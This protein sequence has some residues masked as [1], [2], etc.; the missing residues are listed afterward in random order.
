ML[1]YLHKYLRKPSRARKQEESRPPEMLSPSRNHAGEFAAAATVCC[2]SPCLRDATEQLNSENRLAVKGATSARAAG[3]SNFVK[4]STFS[5]LPNPHFTNHESIPPIL[6][7]FSNFAAV[8]PQY[9]ETQR[10]DVIRDGEYSHLADHVCL[11]YSGVNLFS[12]AQM[13]APAATST[14]FSSTWRPP[15]F[16]ISYKSTSLK[17]EVA[18]GE[19][20]RGFEFSI[21]NRIMS[22]LKITG[23]DYGMVC[24]TNRTAAFRLLGETYPFQSNNK[25]LTVYDYESEAVTAMAESAENRGAKVMSSCFSWPGMRIQ[26][27]QLRKM[28][29]TKK[30]K[31]GLFVFPHMSRMTGVRYPYL[32]LKFAREN[33]WHVAL[34]ACT[35]GPKDMD[36]L[37]IALLQPDFIICSFF[38][39]FG[40]NPL[41]F[42]GLFI[43]K[44]SLEVLQTSVLARSIG[45]VSIIPAGSL[46]D[47]TG[48]EVDDTTSSFS[49][50]IP[51]SSR[52]KYYFDNPVT[53]PEEEG[54]E[55]EEQEEE[56]EEEELSS[57]IVEVR[58]QS[59]GDTQEEIVFSGLDHA[60]SLGLVIIHNRLRCITN[61]LVIAL[62]KL[63]H[64]HSKN[65]S[66]LVRIYGPRVKFDRGPALAFNL[67]DWKGEK[68]NPALVQKLA[69]RGSI[70]LSCGFLQKIMFSEEYEQVKEAVLERR[71]CE[72]RASGNKKRENRNLGITVVNASFGF[73]ANFED[74]YRLWAFVAKFLDADFVEKER[75]KYVSLNQKMIEL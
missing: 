53:A 36:T 10:A 6:E 37:G 17:S 64:P 69:D 12:H 24:T 51:V 29:A 19:Q 54:E 30:K 41:G 67:F 23:E 28:L 57:E 70:S 14:A 2:G 8:F 46:S 16:S 3:R 72:I 47:L 7:A 21:R 22:F 55:T 65:E 33:G 18:H 40:E 26:S 68:I 27:A 42:A 52:E 56:E 60:D 11:D 71:E 13:N 61:W 31:R 1:F 63:R 66:S 62:M 43:K 34:D 32:W 59:T 75:W 74:A 25:L 38:K 9:G 15:F 58:S 73:L 35:L 4:L 48:E 20:N 5:L 49:G 44:S 45:I 50:P 39:V